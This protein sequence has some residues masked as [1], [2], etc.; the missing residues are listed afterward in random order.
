LS[1]YR[2]LLLAAL[3]ALPAAC[4]P[5]PAPA[6]PTWSE[7]F[8]TSAAGALSGVWGAAPDDVWIVGGR[9]G[10]GELYHYDGA[11][12]TRVAPPAGSDLLVWAYGF[13]PR[14]V[15]AVGVGG[16]AIHYDGSAWTALDTGTDADLWGVFGFAPDDLW[17]VGAVATG[18]TAPTILHYDGAAFTPYLL[19]PSQNTRAARSLFKVW[20][21]DGTL[22]AVGQRGLII[23]WDGSDWVETPAGAL[24]DQDF[25]SLWG[26]SA[27]HIVAVGGRN[28]ARI[29]TWDGAAW[30]TLAPTG[31]GGLNAIAMSDPD[32]AVVG[33]IYGWVG[34]FAPA[35]GALTREDGLTHLD[36]H[37]MWGDGRGR[38]YAVG[39]RFVGAFTGV[40]LLR[41]LE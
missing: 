20:G 25:V 4:E 32:E 1:A 13:G 18:E 12:W 14:D 33:G 15:F 8:D 31:L 11:A 39:G 5:D 34:T 2:T 16:T 17:V 22:F 40:A 24:A 7:A 3:L 37:A 27:D 21:I 9:P 38:V 23:R 30:T 36:V 26:T 29:A 10:A 19:D 35:S 6:T 28:N 41:T